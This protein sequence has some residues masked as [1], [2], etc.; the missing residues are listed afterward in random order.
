MNVH[1][2]L[3]ILNSIP[4]ARRKERVFA[5]GR[6]RDA[7]SKQVVLDCAIVDTEMIS[8]GGFAWQLSIAGDYDAFPESGQEVDPPPAKRGDS[9]HPGAHLSEVV[10]G[11]DQR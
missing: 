3:T 7:T 5:A 4:E 2:L 6:V 9:R 11:D 10:P 1:Q 8:V